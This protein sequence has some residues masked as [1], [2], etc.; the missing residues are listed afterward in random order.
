MMNGSI[1]SWLINLLNLLAPSGWG[2]SASRTPTNNGV[3][4]VRVSTPCGPVP[5]RG[6]TAFVHRPRFVGVVD[7][8]KAFCSG[9]GT[10][11][12]PGGAACKNPSQSAISQFV[13]VFTH[14]AGRYRPEGPPFSSPV[15]GSSWLYESQPISNQQ[16]ASGLEF[17]HTVR[18]GTDR[19][20][21]R[22]RPRCVGISG[23]CMEGS[24]IRGWD[25]VLPGRR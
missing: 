21:H 15:F 10:S 20:D 4:G 1:R 5:S 24:L 18:G 14:G 19:G 2:P 7:V 3:P 11:F 13:G 8:R 23:R 12:F 22:F 25:L 9:D 17:P 16:P 6:I